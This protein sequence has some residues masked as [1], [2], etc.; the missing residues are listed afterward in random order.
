MTI[1]DEPDELL[2]SGCRQLGLQLTPAQY[3]AFTHYSRLIQR[4]NK[5]Y[6]LTALRDERQIVIRHFLDSLSIH[7]NLAGSHSIDVGSGAGFPGLPL[8]IVQPNHAFT[9]LDSNGK[10]CRFLTQVT[11]E[12]ALTN[13]EVV[14]S[15]VQEFA[16]GRYDQ[17]LVRAYGNLS[18]IVRDTARLL[19][20]EGVILAM[21]GATDK[22]ELNDLMVRGW[23]C[24][25]TPLT[26]PHLDE[27][28]HLVTLGRM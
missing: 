6:N 19:G 1:N 23:R 28:R 15:R 12:L 14:Q 21:K 10:R 3:S 26:V 11:I 25:S 7:G 18:Q 22:G 27:Q 5:S 20:D 8:A 9:L 13:I 17:V 2:D 24:S 4:W 16:D